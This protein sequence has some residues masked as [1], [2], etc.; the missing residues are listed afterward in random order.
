MKKGK[1]LNIYPTSIAKNSANLKNAKNDV[2]LLTF[3]I[4]YGEQILEVSINQAIGSQLVNNATPTTTEIAAFA[5][6]ISK[7]PMAR[8]GG[9]TTL[10]CSVLAGSEIDLSNVVYIVGSKESKEEASKKWDSDKV[11]DTWG[12]GEPYTREIG[13]YTFERTNGVF[14]LNILSENYDNRGFAM[15][16][17]L[18]DA[19]FEKDADTF[20]AMAQ[21]RLGKVFLAPGTMANSSSKKP[22]PLQKADNSFSQVDWEDTISGIEQI[23][24][25]EKAEQASKLDKSASN[26]T[27]LMNILQ[28]GKSGKK[29]E[30]QQ[31][32]EIL[33]A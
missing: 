10:A 18:Q 27:E 26:L 4:E 1:I 11:V 7:D 5:E 24:G 9:A 14:T 20:A 3:K 2:N 15:W 31:E 25:K 16:D 29:K 28:S 17:K 30:A 8:N 12:D 32:L 33:V 19:E 22:D 13:G 21:K 6:R 23:F